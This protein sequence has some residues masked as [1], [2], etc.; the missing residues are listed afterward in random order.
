MTELETLQAKHREEAARK[1]AK[2]KERKARA[3]RLI[4]RGAILESAINEICPA[5]NLTNEQVQDIVY[6]AILAP[7]TITYISEMGV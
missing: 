3:H 7:S 6:Y 2:L 4:E 1:R 5:Q